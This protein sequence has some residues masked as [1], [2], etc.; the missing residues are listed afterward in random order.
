M[1]TPVYFIADIHLHTF[2]TATEEQ[3]K[4]LLSEFLD[5]VRTRQGTLFI[6]GDMFD[7]WFEYRYVIPGCYFRVLR[8]LQEL[9]ES[10][11]EVHFIGGNHDYWMKDFFSTEL[12]ISVHSQPLDIV[13]HNKRFYITHADGILPE[14]SG[15]RRWRTIMRS[16][17]AIRLFGLLHP[18]VAF[19][20]GSFIS[21]RS[22]R[23]N[24]RPPEEDEAER[25]ALIRYGQRLFA[26]GFQY[27]ITGHFHL[28]TVYCEDRNVFLNLGDWIRYFSFGY[29]DGDNLN[30]AYWGSPRKPENV[31]NPNFSLT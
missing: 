30:L 13:L 20:F 6:V 29:F 26:D 3:K 16:R 17:L 14:E 24:L 8:Q 21:S 1:K 10:G 25:Q 9:T 23:L 15:Y 11:C 12:H 28:P 22:R 2:P 5:E 18:D 31:K 19:R 7:F 4:R 27:V